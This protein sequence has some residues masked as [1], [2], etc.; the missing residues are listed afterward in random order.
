MAGAWQIRADRLQW[1]ADG[2]FVGTDVWLSRCDC[3]RPPWALRAETVTGELGERATI[4]GGMLE[5]CGKPVLPIPWLVVPMRERRPGLRLPE[6]GYTAQG[7]RVAQPVF[8]ALGDPVDL[9]L[10]PE[11]RS[12]GAL[13]LLTDASVRTRAGPDAQLMGAIGRDRSAGGA[14]GM[15][16][17]EAAA[18]RGPLYGSIDSTWISDSRYLSD[19]GVDF[20]GRT[21]PWT[22]SLV[23]LGAGPLRLESDTF[24][25]AGPD[26][27]A[28]AQ[29]PIAGVLR[30]AGRPIGPLSSDVGAR[31]DMVDL[32]GTAP[33]SAERLEA[34]AGLAGGR[35]LGPASI[36]GRIEGR[37]IQWADST[38]WQEGRVSLAA[39]VGLWGDAGPLRHVADIGVEGAIAGVLGKPV[40]QLLED[41][42]A[43]PWSLGPSL[44]SR[45]LSAVGV[46]VSL[47]ASLPW[48]PAGLL[49]T[50][51]GHLQLERWG[52][53]LGGSGDLQEA[54]TWWGDDRLALGLGAVHYGDLLQGQGDVSWVLPAPAEAWRPGWRTLHDLASGAALSQGP[55]LGYDSAC[56]CLRVEARAAWSEDRA[57]PEFWVHLELH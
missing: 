27:Q 22:E 17:A 35:V 2:R 12:Q 52:A 4:R 31:V 1:T 37:T 39:R 3:E 8:L 9:T 7:W 15:L 57:L 46:P 33:S 42:P 18:V 26:T 36:E 6:V 40:V 45:W 16:D 48:T 34:T 41:Q 47:E 28:L 24:G 5:L 49:P 38:A 51:A 14:R 55:T 13:R 20:L 32:G 54:R 50:G 30:M 11:W 25:P 10:A 19:Y 21:V 23:S 43:Q 44:R 56:D 53:R 29:R